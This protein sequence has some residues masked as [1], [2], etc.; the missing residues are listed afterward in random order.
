ME[1]IINVKMIKNL[2]IDA[3]VSPLLSEE[4]SKLSFS[5]GNTDKMNNGNYLYMGHGGGKEKERGVQSHRIHRFL[6]K[7]KR[8]HCRG[9]KLN[10]KEEMR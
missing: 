9:E 7:W 8:V 2:M 4:R 5:V 1:A 10:W 3:I 6:T